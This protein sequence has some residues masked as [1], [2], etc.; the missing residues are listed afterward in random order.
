MLCYERIAQTAESL[1]RT[2]EGLEE[3]EKHSAA[4]DVYLR[5]AA[6]SKEKEEV[7]QQQQKTNYHDSDSDNGIDDDDDGK[8]E[9]SADILSDDEEEE[10]EDAPAFFITEVA[11][12][13]GKENVKRPARGKKGIAVDE[14]GNVI[15]VG[16]D[17]ASNKQHEEDDDKNMFDHVDK[18][19]PATEV[20]NPPYLFVFS[21]L[22]AKYSLTRTPSLL[23]IFLFHSHHSS[24]SLLYLIFFFFF[25]SNIRNLSIRHA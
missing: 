25:F 8:Y 5:A 21:L 10:E 19:D 4:F 14:E 15:D 18:F 13:G 16:Y 1:K 7:E 11:G 6:I 3:L 23:F 17:D 2:K 24:Y 20:C 9:K 22:C 12:G